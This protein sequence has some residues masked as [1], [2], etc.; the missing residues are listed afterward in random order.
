[1]GRFL[2]DR[3]IATRKFLLILL[4]SGV[5]LGSPLR[6]H[7]ALNYRAVRQRDDL[8]SV[9]CS[10]FLEYQVSLGEAALKMNS[11]GL[12]LRYTERLFDMSGKKRTLCDKRV[13]KASNLKWGNFLI[14]TEHLDENSLPIW[15][16][17]WS[18]G[19]DW[20]LVERVAAASVD[21][22]PT[23]L[24]GYYYLAQAKLHTGQ[25]KAARDV[26]LQA[27]EVF[28][29]VALIHR[30]LARWN[31]MYGD[32]SQ[33]FAWYQQ[34]LNLEPDEPTALLGKWRTSL[35]EETYKLSDQEEEQLRALLG[36][37][38]PA[39]YTKP[40]GRNFTLKGYVFDQAIFDLS[41]GSD[42]VWYGFW[43][44]LD[45]SVDPPDQDA[46]WT[47]L[48]DFWIS[49]ER[50]SNL[51]PNAQ[52]TWD[53]SLGIGKLP[54]GYVDLRE[55]AKLTDHALIMEHRRGAEKVCAQLLN[56]S[57]N[58]TGFYTLP[59]P[60]ST[61]ACYFESGWIKSSANANAY[62][63]YQW[64]NG[65][66]EKVGYGYAASEIQ[67]V[68]WQPYG[69]LIMSVE[70]AKHVRLRLLNNLAEGNVCFNDVVFIPVNCW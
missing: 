16:S 9:N 55:R 18:W 7:L 40:D 3:V 46:N 28:P 45:E 41:Q 65:D 25:I 20:P 68:D 6:A 44:A 69:E 17:M 64:L 47:K 34:A 62:L 60:L 56:V 49:S 59:I 54:T 8:Y 22:Y 38:Y 52:F 57:T 29:E 2:A 23:H 66:F 53:Q 36:S 70:D 12:A 24:F 32:K 27:L 33:A 30:E 26:Y 58:R 67:G 43:R 50:V 19:N 48:D 5:L 1:M 35:E 31:Y 37:A 4:I 21:V 63:G 61:D 15:L 11:R 42:I 13:L 51:A 10:A 14:E 39:G